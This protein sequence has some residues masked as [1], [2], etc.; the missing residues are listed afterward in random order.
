MAYIVYFVD[1]K[2]FSFFTD[3]SYAVV[4]EV[5]TGW[6]IT[7]TSSSSST[8]TKWTT[9]GSVINSTNGNKVVLHLNPVNDRHHNEEYVCLGFNSAGSLV[10]H[11]HLT[12]IVHGKETH[13]PYPSL[14]D[15]DNYSTFLNISLPQSHCPRYSDLTALHVLSW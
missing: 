9:G 13:N 14:H 1:E 10:Y 2:N 15:K 3:F 7:C 8:T 11:L 6:N 4:N 12:I 5:G